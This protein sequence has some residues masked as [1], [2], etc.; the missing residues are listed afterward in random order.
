M[1]YI[2][3]KLHEVKAWGGESE[4][5]PPGE[6]YVLMIEKAE[7]EQS[8]GKGTLQLAVSVS[9]LNEGEVNGRK[10]KFWYNIDPNAKE[11]SRKRLRSLIDAAG[12]PLDQAGGFDDQQLV[13]K[14]FVADVVHES[15]KKT[16]ATT[17][18]EV[19]QMNARIKNERPLPNQQPQAAPPPPP[20][21]AA[22]PAFAPPAGARMTATK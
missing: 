12:I 16:D 14:V 20:P 15:Y 13:G 21:P 9:V 8:S 4:M 22:R 11:G 1:A 5:L 18:T 19:E 7:Q 17:G 2:G 6:D 10:A 3:Q